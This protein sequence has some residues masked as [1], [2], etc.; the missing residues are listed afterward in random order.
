MVVRGVVGH[1]VH[2]DV[3][4]APVGVGDQPVEVVQR[5]EQRIDIGVNP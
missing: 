1:V 4:A 5:P 2:D 3:E